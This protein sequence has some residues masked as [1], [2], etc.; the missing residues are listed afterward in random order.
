MRAAQSG[1]LSIK[2][3]LGTIVRKGSLLGVISDP[4]GSNK[5]LVHSLTEGVIIGKTNLQLVSQGDALFHR[6]NFHGN[7]KFSE[8]Q[9]LISDTLE[10][11]YYL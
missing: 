1:T 4:F 2:K 11:S 6:G 9:V 8:E 10:D 3:H 5:C 7:T